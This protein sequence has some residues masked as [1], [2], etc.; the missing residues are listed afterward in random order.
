V[1]KREE[2]EKRDATRE[3]EKMGSNGDV[4]EKMRERKREREGLI[5]S[6]R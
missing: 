4:M 2:K 5:A 6:G 3:G 1:R